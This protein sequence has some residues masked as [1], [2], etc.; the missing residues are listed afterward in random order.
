LDQAD[1]EAL[2]RRSRWDPRDLIG[3]GNPKVTG[4]LPVAL[5][6]ATKVVKG[7]LYSGKEYVCLMQLHA[8]VPEL[9]LRQVLG[10]FEGEIY[11]KPPMRSSVKREPRK[12]SIYKLEVNEINGRTVLFTCSCQAGTY[13]RKLC[14]DV[15]EVLGCGAHMRELRRTRAGPLKEGEG[16]VTMHELSVAQ[17]ELEAGNEA[18]MRAIIKPMEIAL[19][20]LP[21]VVIRDSAVDAVCHGAELAIPGIVKLDSV[22]EKGKP[23]AVFSLKG[24]A[25][26]I[27]R[28]QMNSRDVLDLEKGVAVKTE[29]VLMER[30]TYP[31]MWKH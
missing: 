24:E 15:G 31:A 7:F 23:V 10:E 16:M 17:S 22:V 12:R 21:K 1:D 20:A 28:A 25:V 5:E 4:V 2:T 18:P 13:M 8:D 19:G 27:G 29:R 14:S 9:T 6:D 30:S 26:A 11:Q 3:R